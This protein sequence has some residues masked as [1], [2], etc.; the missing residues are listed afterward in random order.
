MSVDGSRIGAV[1]ANLR[2]RVA[3]VYER[4]QRTL[5]WQVWERMLE[6]EFVDRGVALAGKA[7]VSFFPLVIVVAAFLPAHARHSVFTTLIDWFG[8]GGGALVTVKRAFASSDQIRRATGTLGLVLTIFY[9]TSFTTA[10]QRVYLRSWRR[11]KGSPAGTYVRAPLWFLVLLVCMALL[12]TLSGLFGDGAELVV[13]AVVALA[14][15]SALWLFTSWLMLM[16]QVRWRVLIPSA[17][18]TAVAT[19]LFAVT[20]RFWMPR[21]VTQNFTQFGFF[22]VAL[23]LVTWFSGTAIC[24]VLGTCAGAVLAEDSGRLGRLIRG[25]KATMLVD[26]APPEL[27]APAGAPRARDALRPADDDD[28]PS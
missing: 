18:L 25:P 7:F 15:T 16:G 12:G 19:D 4:L 20:A 26:G 23:A 21:T 8:L 10:L 9:A 22:G 5:V 6:I 27:P 13:F 24:I 17:L 1:I 11:P 2:A 28:D 3:P 14:A